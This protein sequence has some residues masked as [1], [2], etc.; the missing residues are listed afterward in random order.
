MIGEVEPLKALEAEET[1]GKIIKRVLAEYPTYTLTH[2]D[3]PFYRV[4]K[5]PEK[6]DDPLQYDGP[7]DA[8]LGRGRFDAPNF[9]VLYASP[10]LEVCVHESRMTAEDDLYV[11]TMKPAVPLKLLNLAALLKDEEGTEF[12]SLDIAVH[13]LFLAGSH[14]FGI[15]RSIADAGKAAGFDGLIYP[16]YFSL[17]RLGVMPYQTVYG[18]SYR[19]I[20][21]LQLHEEARTVQNLALFGRPVSE[22]KVRVECMNRLIIR[23]V[24]YEFHFGP[25][26]N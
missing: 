23:R 24:G 2:A 6:P 4:R 19:R 7:P 16:S 9:P 1:R 13:M 11:A 26:R 22:K 8:M 25:V 18:I 10:D 3:P 5:S 17:L 15:S 20:P 12:E 21:S 14:S